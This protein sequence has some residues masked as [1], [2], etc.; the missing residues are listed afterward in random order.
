METPKFC[1]DSQTAAAAWKTIK[2]STSCRQLFS[3]HPKISNWKKQRGD[4]D[5]RVGVLLPKYVARRL[6]QF[7]ANPHPRQREGWW[8]CWCQ[9]RDYLPLLPRPDTTSIYHWCCCI[10]TFD[11]LFGKYAICWI[12]PHGWTPLLFTT[13]LHSTHTIVL[14]TNEKGKYEIQRHGKSLISLPIDAIDCHILVSSVLGLI[15]VSKIDVGFLHWRKF[16]HPNF[17][18]CFG[19]KPNQIKPANPI[20]NPAP[21]FRSDLG[22]RSKSLSCEGVSCKGYEAGPRWQRRCTACTALWVLIVAVRWVF[23]QWVGPVWSCTV[24][25]GFNDERRWYRFLYF[26]SHNVCI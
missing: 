20:W 17:W 9:R 25:N 26:G 18:S 8:V 12:I 16:Y 11:Q 3:A 21:P 22:V 10:P 24:E 23:N 14:S 4:R 13:K 6:T 15:S 19:I 1:N 7:L 2:I 5:G